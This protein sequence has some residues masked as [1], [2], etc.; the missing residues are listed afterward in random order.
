MFIICSC[1]QAEVKGAHEASL[2]S[3]AWHPAGHLLA[4]GAADTTTKF[5]CRAR[6]G[7]PWRDRNQREQEEGA[8]TESGERKCVGVPNSLRLIFPR[9]KGGLR[10]REN[11]WFTKMS[12]HFKVES[13]GVEVVGT[14]Q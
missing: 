11:V 12:A 13:P 7:D 14:G 6:P 3:L 8:A 1:L 2:L 5:W 10:V 9:S 4:T